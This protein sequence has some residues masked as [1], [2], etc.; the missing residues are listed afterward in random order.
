MSIQ[1]EGQTPDVAR[2]ELHRGPEGADAMH[3]MTLTPQAR[4]NRL[5]SIKARAMRIG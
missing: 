4:D 2:D 5:M 3:P 1:M